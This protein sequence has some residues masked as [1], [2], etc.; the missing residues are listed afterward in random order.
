MY[1]VSYFDRDECRF[2]RNF[3]DMVDAVRCFRDAVWRGMHCVRLL[4]L[5]VDE[6]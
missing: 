5:E 1:E 2:I 3:P 4:Y 6:I